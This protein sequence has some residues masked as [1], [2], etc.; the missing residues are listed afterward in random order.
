LLGGFVTTYLSWR[1]AFF[2][3]DVVIDG[4]EMPEQ[5]NIK[6]FTFSQDGSH[7]GYV[8]SHMPEGNVVVIDGK[9]NGGKVFAPMDR[10]I[11]F[12]ADGKHTVWGSCGFTTIASWF[13]MVSRRRRSNSGPSSPA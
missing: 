12:S 4:Q 9:A 8:A 2:L 10:A 6:E 13:A 7:F 1:V 5:T 3:E 11:A